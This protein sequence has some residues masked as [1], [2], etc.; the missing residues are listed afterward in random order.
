MRRHW[1]TRGRGWAVGP[2][3]NQ[4]NV[5]IIKTAPKF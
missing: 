4:L 1:T 3:K 5:I 2:K